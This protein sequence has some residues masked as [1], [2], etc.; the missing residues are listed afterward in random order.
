MSESVISARGLSKHYR[1]RETTS[2]KYGSDLA[3]D[4]LEAG[5]ALIRGRL[6]KSAHAEFRA[7]DDVSFDIG[8]GEAVGLLGRN[9][10]GKST[11]LKTLARVVRPTRGEA[12]LHGRIGSLLE[13]GT[14]FHPDLTGR[15]NV[16]LA[17]AILG[18]SRSD[19]RARFDQIV[20]FAEIGPFLETPVKRYSSGMYTRLAYSVAA[21]L[22]ADILL[23][24]E[25]LA[26]GDAAFQRKCLGQMNEA[27]RQGRTVVFVSHNLTQVRAFCT[28]GILLQKGR[29]VFDGSIG[30]AIE[31]LGS[32]SESARASVEWE[33]PERDGFRFVKGWVRQEGVEI[34]SSIDP[35]DPFVVGV[36]FEVTSHCPGL[37][38]GFLMSSS[39][40]QIVTGANHAL[41]GPEE[42]LA[43]GL[44]TLEVR[45]PGDVLNWGEYNIY[46]GAELF[47]WKRELART[48][49]DLRFKIEDITGRDDGPRPA[50]P[51]MI[52]PR[53]E[54]TRT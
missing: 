53:L 33:A 5:R 28:R 2:G 21:H 13:V 35:R 10:A 45:L 32:D 24:D 8:A 30:E 16:F 11:L 12:V 15:E 51:G 44:H 43:P 26:V 46:F 3:D 6:P 14:G 39:E 1:I 19:I 36:Q 54:W 48:P 37:R 40:N 42:S 9:G 17:G 49:P 22:E 38:M 25:V 4:L 50:Y 7:L 52:R 23:V 31:R 34:D 41:T 27:T 29:L 20:E 47:P 18:L